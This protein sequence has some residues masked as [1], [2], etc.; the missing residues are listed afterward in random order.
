MI[1]KSLFL[2]I[3]VFFVFIFV[4]ITGNN[5]QA[6][7]LS[8]KWDWGIRL[9]LNATSITSYKAYQADEILTN[10]SYTNKNGYSITGFARYNFNKM[11]LQPEISWNE[12]NR[13]CSF[14]LPVENTGNYYPPVNLNIH[15]KTINPNFL[16][17]Y[18]IVKDYPFLFGAF[19]G[20]SVIG[21]YRTNYSMEWEQSFSKTGLSLDYSGIL[22][23]SINI[24]KIYFDLR[25]EMTLPNAK[26][27][28]KEIPNLPENYQDISIKK[29]EAI[30]SF[31]FGVMF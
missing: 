20:I 3:F 11:F 27:D 6:Q 7:T 15:S 30:L 13:T 28:L 26:L 31:S 10:S 25:Y 16:I 9:G 17:G 1:N 19:V 18:N 4:Y 23:F 12:Y 2:R 22:G 8:I 21:T 14:S 29:T 5:I 24:S